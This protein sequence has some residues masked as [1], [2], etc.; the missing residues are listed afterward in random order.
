MRAERKREKNC[1]W[2]GG[3]LS[4]EV[5]HRLVKQLCSNLLP[6]LQEH[7]GEKKEGYSRGLA[8]KY[9]SSFM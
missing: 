6:L 8:E 3:L 4:E 9:A 7:L 2:G 1:C 5:F